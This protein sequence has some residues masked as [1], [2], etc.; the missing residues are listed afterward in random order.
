MILYKLLAGRL[1]LDVSADG[2]VEASRRIREETPPPLS[3]FN[4]ALRGDLTVITSK[5][6][7]KDRNRRYLSASALREDVQ[8]FLEQRPILARGDSTFYLVRK[9]VWRYR[10]L[11][12]VVLLAIATLTLFSVMS[13]LHARRSEQLA[14]IAQEAQRETETSEKRTQRQ[15]YFSSIG[16][17][18]AALE[19]NDMERVHALLNGCDPAFR[20]WEWYYLKRLCDLSS[21]TRDL[22]L[23]RPRYASFTADRSLVALASLGREITLIDL[24]TGQERLRRTTADGAMRAAISPDGR[25]LAFGSV[26]QGVT[27][28]DI[29]SGAD[30]TLPVAKPDSDDPSFQNMR[31]MAF[32]DDSRSL[33]TAGLDKVLRVWSLPDLKLNLQAPLGSSL[34]ICMMLSHDGRTAFLGDNRHQLRSIDLTTGKVIREF[35]GHDAPVWSLALSPNGQWLASG[36][37]D[38]RVIVWD[39]ADGH[40][41]AQLDTNDGWLT[42]LCF[43]PKGDV[44]ALGR[45][46]A[47]IRLLSLP[48]TAVI[49]VLRGHRHAVVNMFWNSDGLQSVSLDGTMK[50]WLPQ[51]ALQV[52][53]IETAQTQCIGL[54]VLPDQK[55]LV[56]GGSDG[57]VIAYSLDTLAGD[58]EPTIR[59]KYT[60][61][62]QQVLEV[63]ACAATNELFTTGRDGKIHVSDISSGWLLRTI[64]PQQ[65]PI[66][67]LDVSTNGK[68]LIVGTAQGVALWD[69][70]SGEK[71]RDYACSA[72]AN[73]ARFTG[74]ASAFYLACADGHLRRYELNRPNAVIDIALDPTGLYDVC[75]SPDGQRIVVGGDSA[76]VI[77]L[78]GRTHKE[79]RRFI[80]HQGPVFGVA[81]HPDG[82]RL[83]SCGS[84]R[85]I[86]IWEIETGTELVSLRGHR[87]LVQHI[88]FTQD[89]TTLA[90]TS[91]DGSVRLWRAT[92][93]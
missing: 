62:D 36:D 69:A 41:V 29:P 55:T 13:T 31:A 24:K 20:N 87:R 85:S 71:I 76:S 70:T 49:G 82:T 61:H 86:R 19:N 79:I 39:V 38:G 83:A 75:I 53:T 30:R 91:D 8:R 32:T 88:E 59:T 26:V 23:D 6:L 43:N 54:C 3:L 42:S 57:S 60:S 65:G 34:P 33:V 63:T 46:D 92:P 35:A 11:A 51:S 21:G 10:A 2:L 7:E 16:F 27:L 12:A 77:L 45:S 28:R 58:F 22:K 37:N 9:T 80:G 93:R 44:L 81:L 72:V 52:P 17:A 40:I 84:D 74:D 15:L 68:F 18:Q 50:R 66:A 73:E 4:R 78:D 64:D 5:A 56:S 67:A 48:G 14:H 47:T 25:W 89:G 1:P 90:S